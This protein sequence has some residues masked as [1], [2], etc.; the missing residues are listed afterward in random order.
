AAVGAEVRGQLPAGGSAL[1]E[2]LSELLSFAARGGARSNHPVSGLLVGAPEGG[3]LP[4]V[5]R[6]PRQSA[7]ARRPHHPGRRG[8]AHAVVGGRGLL[9][10]DRAGLSLWAQSRADAKE[11]G[12]RRRAGRW[13]GEAGRDLTRKL[14]LS[15]RKRDRGRGPRKKVSSRCG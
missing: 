4:D 12:E 3:D 8:E 9:G 5:P 1:L 11:R 7:P 14:T 10:A 13:C 15:L 2:C 6:A